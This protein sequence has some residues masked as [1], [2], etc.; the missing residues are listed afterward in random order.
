MNW[1]LVGC[2]VVLGMA[3]YCFGMWRGYKIGVKMEKERCYGFCCALLSEGK[4]SASARRVM[5][6]IQADRDTLISEDEFFG[7]EK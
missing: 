6:S 5:H 1:T 7:V 3:N 4:V 2:I